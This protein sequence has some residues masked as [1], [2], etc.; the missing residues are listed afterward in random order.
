MAVV[1]KRMLSDLY[2]EAVAELER[3]TTQDWK[4]HPS[5]LPAPSETWV[6]AIT[7]QRGQAVKI[8]ITRDLK[9]RL[10][11]LQTGYPYRLAVV[12]SVTAPAA[13]E[14][15]LHHTF[16]KRRLM[17]EWFDFTRRNAVEAITKAAAEWESAQ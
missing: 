17:G 1:A 14:E 10:R 11:T 15:H 9:T 3:L 7:D 2:P 8:G 4:G 12:W 6:Y 5:G 13:L 16:R